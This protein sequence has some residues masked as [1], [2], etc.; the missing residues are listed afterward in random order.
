VKKVSFWAFQAADPAIA[1]FGRDVEMFSELCRL[2]THTFFS[3]GHSFAALAFVVS[4]AK[5]L[6]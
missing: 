6:A 1:G 2:Q 5:K 4:G 3:I